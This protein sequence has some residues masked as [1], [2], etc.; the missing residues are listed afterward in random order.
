V[1]IV[2]SPAAFAVIDLG[3]GGDW[4]QHKPVTRPLYACDN[5][6]CERFNEDR[7][8]DELVV[9]GPGMWQVGDRVDHDGRVEAIAAI[10]VGLPHKVNLV[11]YLTSGHMLGLHELRPPPAHHPGQGSLLA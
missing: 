5:R 6:A 3:E 2:P 10:D 7:P 11:A 1:G 4:P 8:A 9:P